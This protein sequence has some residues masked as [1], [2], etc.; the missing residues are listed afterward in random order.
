MQHH[1]EVLYGVHFIEDGGDTHPNLDRIDG[2]IE[3]EDFRLRLEFGGSLQ[4]VTAEWESGE[5]TVIAIGERYT[6]RLRTL[7]AAFEDA[8]GEPGV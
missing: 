1:S 6:I 8:Q 5:G 2:V 7:F 3:A 4:G